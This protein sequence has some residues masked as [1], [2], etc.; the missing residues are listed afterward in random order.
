MSQRSVE[1]VIGKL[2]TDEGFRRRFAQDPARALCETLDCV[3]E[4][5]PC[6]RRALASINMDTIDRLAREIDP[7]LQKTEIL[8]GLH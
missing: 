6:E 1:R 5:T 7:R 8:G 4:L 2:V 3:L